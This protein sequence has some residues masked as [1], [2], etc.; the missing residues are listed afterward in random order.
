MA[1]ALRAR[2]VTAEGFTMIES[3]LR[4]DR[5][6]RAR[7]VG[8]IIASACVV[9]LVGLIWGHAEHAPIYVGATA[10]AVAPSSQ[11]GPFLRA[12]ANVYA[13]PSADQVFASRRGSP[14]DD[15]P[16]APTF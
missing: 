12:P 16:A 3:N 15:A 6:S 7:T 1:R 13:I 10:Q 5:T 11:D 9:G 2:L 4:N 8:A 14:E